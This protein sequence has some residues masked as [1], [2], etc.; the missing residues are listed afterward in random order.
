MIAISAPRV[1]KANITRGEMGK[2]S[3]NNTPAKNAAIAKRWKILIPIIVTLPMV[4]NQYMI[5]TRDPARIGQMIILLFMI[6][7]AKVSSYKISKTRN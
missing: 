5:P 7:T 1:T 6:V 2:V 4:A 3:L